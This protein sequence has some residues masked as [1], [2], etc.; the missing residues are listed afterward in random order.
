[1]RLPGAWPDSDPESHSHTAPAAPKQRRRRLARHP[2]SDDKTVVIA[3]MG[4]TGAGKSTFIKN[5]TRQESVSVGESLSSDTSHVAAYELRHKGVRY[6]LV[7][8]PGF[9]DTDRPDSEI[10][11]VILTWLK[12]SLEAG[13]E[14]NGVIYLHRI[15]DPRMSG[16][17]LR[18]TRMFRKLIGSDGFGN[19]VLATTF[20][21]TVLESIGAGREKELRTNPDFWGSMVENGAKMARLQNTRTSGLE[22]LEKM[23]QQGKFV[24]DVQDEVVN[25]GKSVDETEVLREQM[26]QAEE[27]R[28]TLKA[29]RLMEEERLQQQLRRQES[30]RQKQLRREWREIEQRRAAEQRAEK[31]RQAEERRR[32]EEQIRREEE[33]LRQELERQERR[34][35]EQAAELQRRAKAEEKRRQEEEANIRRRFQAAYT[36]IGYKAQWPCDKCKGSITAYSSYYREFLS[37]LPALLLLFKAALL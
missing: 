15:F 30:A 18:N 32:A 20:W 2:S 25:Q 36:C 19:V 23:A 29:Q 14:L 22:L 13:T 16:S 8:T 21:G 1:M 9:N 33:E 26:A 11:T 10:T 5:V 35:R 4:V 31:Q 17:A 7:D 27:L 28:R 6:I 3:V 24:L 12:E 37:S 34:R